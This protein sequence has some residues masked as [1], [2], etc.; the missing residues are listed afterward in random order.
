MQLFRLLNIS[1][2]KASRMNKKQKR[3]KEKASDFGID[4]EFESDY[5]IVNS[6]NKKRKMRFE[7]AE[8]YVSNV[9]NKFNAWMKAMSSDNFLL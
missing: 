9:E 8:V 1:G 4:I 3:L 5:C 7:D 2:M 6:M